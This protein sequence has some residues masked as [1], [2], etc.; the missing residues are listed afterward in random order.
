V[1]TSSAALSVLAGYGLS[2][3]DC[4][5]I[6]AY[7]AGAEYNYALLH[8][9]KLAVN[10]EELL[11]ISE[12]VLKK[13][14]TAYITGRKEFYGLEFDLCSGVFIPRPESELLTELAIK[15]NPR[16][17][18]DLCTG[19]GA[20]L[21]SILS[22]LK[23][24][25]GAGADISL[26]AIETAE[27]NARKLGVSDRTEFFQ[28]DL[29]ASSLPYGDFDLITMNPPYLSER[30][31][32]ECPPSIFY[33]PKNA[34]AAESEGYHFY[35]IILNELK[36]FNNMLLLFEIGAA[37]GETVVRLA[38]NCGFEVSLFNDLAERNR[39]IRAHKR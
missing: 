4:L 24:A 26:K 19:T 8:A 36:K 27:R 13:E 25:R 31:Y 12:R 38:E 34:L 37:Q 29:L 32:A 10:E 21:I 20:I 30:E 16:R 14:P 33:E 5:D 15:E 11:R 7:L 9:G 2:R 28:A 18:L 3:S 1:I 22:E 23:D 35:N 17:V 39:V 6:A